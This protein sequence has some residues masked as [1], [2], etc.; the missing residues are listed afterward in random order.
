MNTNTVANIEPSNTIQHI[1]PTYEQLDTFYD[2]KYKV[3]W[4]YMHAS[5]RPC[6]TPTLLKSL[7][8]LTKDVEA[9]MKLTQQKKYDY[10]VI[11]SRVEGVFNLGGDLDLFTELAMKKDEALLLDYAI[12]CV[13]AIYAN[14]NHIYSDLTTVSLVQGDALG[15][16][17]ETA[18]AS[19]LLIAE[20]GTKMGLPEVIFNLFPGMGA[21]TF[22]RMKVGE[23]KAREII[24]SGTMY[25]A[26]ELYEMGVVDILAEQGEG[27]LALYRYID[28]AKKSPN[29]Y[30][31]VAKMRD[32]FEKVSYDE[33]VDIAKLWVETALKLSEKDLKMMHRLVKRQTSKVKITA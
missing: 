25:S 3:V 17:F 4:L 12:A 30:K 11:A 19:N 21:Y 20:K 1:S 14:H 6:F 7:L 10:L 26:E 22:L 31:A 15:G 23:A 9:E 18:L 5:P 33:L 29:S 27:E 28:K 13:D 8:K 16:G 32:A 24:L 2:E